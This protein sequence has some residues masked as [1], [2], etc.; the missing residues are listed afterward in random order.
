ML[1]IFSERQRCGT[2]EIGL[3]ERSERKTLSAVA[4]TV[5]FALVFVSVLIAAEL[6]PINRVDCEKGHRHHGGSLQ[7]GRAE[8]V[9]SQDQD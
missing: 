4:T 7:T 2:A 3:P 9:E 8:S 6:D 5:L 1:H